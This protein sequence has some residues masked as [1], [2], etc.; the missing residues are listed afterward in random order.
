[1]HNFYITFAAHNATNAGGAIEL[2]KYSFAGNA[3]TTTIQSK[4]LY[5]WVGD[6]AYTPT[7]AVDAS[8]PPSNTQLLQGPVGLAYPP[9]GNPSGNVYVS[10]QGVSP[11]LPYGGTSGAFVGPYGTGGAFSLP[12]YQSFDASGNLYTADSANRA[13]YRTAGGITSPLVT[14]DVLNAPRGV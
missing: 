8:P 14:S 3:P 9:A 10:A 4:L 7:L 12:Q 1:G 11:L 2:Q 6:A 13:V 5:Q